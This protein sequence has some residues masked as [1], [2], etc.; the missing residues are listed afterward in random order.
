M[1]IA[2]LT[3]TVDIAIRLNSRVILWCTKIW[4]LPVVPENVMRGRTEIG[5]WVNPST[6]LSKD[7]NQK[8]ELKNDI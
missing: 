7:S 3:M 4:T 2:D 8:K 6:L 1:K 5:I